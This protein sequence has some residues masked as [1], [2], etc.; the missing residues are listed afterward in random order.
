MRFDMIHSRMMLRTFTLLLA[1]S[2]AA[3]GAD[4]A[5][6]SNAQESIEVTLDG[7]PFTTLYFGPETTKPYFHPVRAA[8]GTVVS[9]GYPM[10]P[11]VP[12]E[13]HDHQHQRGL[14]FTHGD[15][16]GLDFWGNEADYPDQDKKGQIVLKGV[17]KAGDGFIRADFEWR[18]TAGEVLLTDQRTMSFHRWGQNVAI[19]FDILLEAGVKPV[20]FGDTKEGSFAIRLATTMR[21]RKPDKSPGK[22]V[23]VTATGARGAAEAWGKPS[24]WVDYSGPVGDG[25]YGVTIFDHPSNPKHPTYWHVRDY[26]LFAANIFGE[27][28]FFNDKTR[29]G[30]V[31]LA[32]GKTMRFRYRVMIHPGDDSAAHVAAEY[33]KWAQ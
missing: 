20:K 22:G 30:S 32:P 24:P 5:F 8:D 7:K 10:N 15:V 19:D 31:T 27:H 3:W 28:D 25:I 21:E 29:D 18:S 17:H 33:K 16:N 2:L 6:K 9:R 26:G 11:N 1:A 23:I 14:W 12:G 4:F 13:A